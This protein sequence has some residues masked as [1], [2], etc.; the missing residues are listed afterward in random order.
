MEPGGGVSGLGKKYSVDAISPKSIVDTSG[1]NG[2]PVTFAEK[3]ME[4][5]IIGMIH[6]DHRSHPSLVMYSIP[7]EIA[8]DLMNPRIFHLIKV[9]QK[10]NPRAVLLF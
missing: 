5:K 1:K 3:Y 6:K 2:E 9:L 4:A 10:E 8:P 7:D